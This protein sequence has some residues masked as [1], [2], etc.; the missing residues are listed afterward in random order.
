MGERGEN[1]STISINNVPSPP[2]GVALPPF[3]PNRE[4]CMDAHRHHSDPR[5]RHHTPHSRGVDNSIDGWMT[6]Y[7]I[8]SIML[9]MAM[10]LFFLKHS[11]KWAAMTQLFMSG[12]YLFGALGHHGTT[13]PFPVP[14]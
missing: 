5:P 2:S 13:S 4:R 3:Q 14:S 9:L 10:R 11:S 6:D 7:L 1:L 12:G 8:C